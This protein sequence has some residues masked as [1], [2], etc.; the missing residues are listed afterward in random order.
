M[1]AGGLQRKGD[2]ACRSW[3]RPAHAAGAGETLFIQWEGENKNETKR[4][5]GRGGAILI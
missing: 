5:R 2:K 3:F 4:K 1:V